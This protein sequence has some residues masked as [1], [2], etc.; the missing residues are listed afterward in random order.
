[1]SSQS[2]AIEWSLRLHFLTTLSDLKLNITKSSHSSYKLTLTLMVQKTVC[3]LV[4]NLLH[5]IKW[6]IESREPFYFEIGQKVCACSQID[7][8]VELSS[9]LF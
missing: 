5:F 3:H 9:V 2:K 1:M 4:L 6:L 8:H 7:A